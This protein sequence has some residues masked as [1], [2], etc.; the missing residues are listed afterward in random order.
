MTQRRK[1]SSTTQSGA[2]FT[3]REV[4]LLSAAVVFALA[5]AILLSVLANGAGLSELVGDQGLAAAPAAG[6]TG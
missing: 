3:R 4:Q 1:T 2:V 6:S 5:A